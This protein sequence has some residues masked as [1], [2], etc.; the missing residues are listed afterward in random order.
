M[1]FGSACNRAQIAIQNEQWHEGL[2][3]QG[4]KLCIHA[5][6]T[7][8]IL[9]EDITLSPCLATIWP[10]LRK[11]HKI[12]SHVG[13]RLN[14]AVPL[15]VLASQAGDYE[16][17]SDSLGSNAGFVKSLA[18]VSFWLQLPL[19]IVSGCILIFSVYFTN[20]V[21]QSQKRQAEV[22]PSECITFP[23]GPIS[24]L[25]RVYPC[26]KA[27]PRGVANGSSTGGKL[28]AAT[29]TYSLTTDRSWL[30]ALHLDRHTF[31]FELGPIYVKPLP[32]FHNAL[33]WVV[34]YAQL[35]MILSP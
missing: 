18:F 2:C 29:N 34:A 19:S 28:Q 33:L 9:G 12:T 8:G 27:I 25:Y 15:Q 31:I 23:L 3:P 16:L 10:R 35:V 22:G 11:I 21:S 30:A 20:Q 5:V 26:L 32:S 13:E 6:V 4:C 1:P 14:T 24:L 7:V 17:S